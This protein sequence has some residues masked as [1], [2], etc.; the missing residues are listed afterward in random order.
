MKKLLSNYIPGFFIVVLC[1]SLLSKLSYADTDYVIISGFGVEICDV[2]YD[3]PSDTTVVSYFMDPHQVDFSG[4][5]FTI[6]PMQR[7]WMRQEQ[8]QVYIEEID[9]TIATSLRILGFRV[10]ASH[11]IAAS[12]RPGG[13][14]MT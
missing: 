1:L 5:E 7:Q 6:N 9:A 4:E 10:E 8:S 2:Y 3:S 13:S 12:S 14:T 11:R